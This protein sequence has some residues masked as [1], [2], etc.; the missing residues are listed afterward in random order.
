MNPLAPLAFPDHR[1]GR[2]RRS[3]LEECLEAVR[4]HS[5]PDAPWVAVAMSPGSLESPVD[6]IEALVEAANTESE[7]LRK[8]AAGTSVATVLDDLLD[9]G[10]KLYRE[11]SEC[12]GGAFGVSVGGRRD[13]GVTSGRVFR[14]AAQLLGKY[15]IVVCVDEAQ[16]IPASGSTKG[17]MDC[18]H[19]DPQG[20][21][22][23]AAFFGLSDTQKVLR[24]CGLSRFA[25]GRVVTLDLLPLDDSACAI[26]DILGAYGFTGTQEDREVWVNELAERSQRWPQHINRVAVAACDIIQAKEGRI[27]SVHLDE[28]FAARPHSRSPASLP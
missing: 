2:I 21:P 7:R 3:G 15:H 20:I 23:V 12:G 5:T 16:N 17:V 18:L 25:R 4:C 14:K 27:D 19:R 10:R 1:L 11:L 26:R 9:R 24:E 6:V 13:E 8:I 22:L 28:A